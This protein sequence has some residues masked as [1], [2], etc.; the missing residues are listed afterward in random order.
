[1]PSNDIII[2]SLYYIQARGRGKGGERDDAI[3][4]TRATSN[5]HNSNID[6]RNTCQMKQSVAI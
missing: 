4:A 3:R 6:A 5:E 2:I 1:M